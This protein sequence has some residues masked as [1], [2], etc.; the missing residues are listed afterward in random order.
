MPVRIVVGS[1]TKK[2]IRVHVN[3][4]VQGEKREKVDKRR[5]LVIYDDE[6]KLE[7]DEIMKAIE[8]AIVVYAK[9]KGEVNKY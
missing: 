5:N 3:Q 8:K 7:L 1:A 6:G 4:I 2:K 9:T